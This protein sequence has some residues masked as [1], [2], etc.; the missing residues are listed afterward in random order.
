MGQL[1]S[2]ASA[3]ISRSLSSCSIA[4]SSSMCVRCLIVVS[5]RAVWCVDDFK[6]VEV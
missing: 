1:T 4:H 3:A 6:P 5:A 2:L